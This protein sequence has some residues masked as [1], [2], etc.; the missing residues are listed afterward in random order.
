M[1]LRL[2]YIKTSI[3]VYVVFS[4]LEII[5]IFFIVDQDFEAHSWYQ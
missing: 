5:R 1:E 4:L 3:D 2:F